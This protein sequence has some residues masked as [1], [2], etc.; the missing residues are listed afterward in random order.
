M[1]GRKSKKLI[2]VGGSWVIVSFDEVIGGFLGI[3][4]R[5]GVP[6]REDPFHRKVFFIL[7]KVG[8]K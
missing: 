5:K 8:C 1:S 3:E 6:L 4:N 7:E 2:G